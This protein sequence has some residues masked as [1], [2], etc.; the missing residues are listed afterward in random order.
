MELGRCSGISRN[1]QDNRIRSIC[2]REYRGTSGVRVESETKRY[3]VMR[4]D[5]GR[6]DEH[7]KTRAMFLRLDP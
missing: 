4:D 1:R 2:R 7:E 6:L 3:G 5:Y